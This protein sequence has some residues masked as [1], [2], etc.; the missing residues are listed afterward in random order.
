MKKLILT[1]LFTTASLYA[2]DQDDVRIEP[3][4]VDKHGGNLQGFSESATEDLLQSNNVSANFGHVMIENN[5]EKLIGF[6]RQYTFTYQYK[7]Y[8]EHYNNDSFSDTELNDSFTGIY[9]SN[10]WIHPD[11]RRK[12]YGTSLLKYV[13][14]DA[15]NKNAAIITLISLNSENT[16]FYNHCG[17]FH[18]PAL[19]QSCM[20]AKPLNDKMCKLL[21]PATPQ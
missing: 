10:I 15:K 21:K 18:Y 13:D 2:M 3:F 9:I 11:H 14:E 17:Y 7:N 5:S 16:P 12:G 4:G 1:L 6:V 19:D 20:M 8:F